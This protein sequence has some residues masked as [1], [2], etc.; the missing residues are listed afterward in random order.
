MSVAAGIQGR[1]PTYS[2]SMDVEIV[3]RLAMDV[4]IAQWY[5]F[6]TN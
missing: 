1:V 6:N 4:E 2:L 3:S 5:G